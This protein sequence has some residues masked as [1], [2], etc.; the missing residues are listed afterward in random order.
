MSKKAL[1]LP[2]ILVF[3]VIALY[4]CVLVPLLQYVGSDI[5][6]SS[7]LWLDFLDLLSHH[8]EIVGGILV[9]EFLIFVLYRYTL[10][11]AKALLFVIAGAILF[12][13]AAAIIAYSVVFGS[14]DLTGSLSGYAVALAL[15]FLIAALVLLLSVRS[16][17]PAQAQFEA[18]A[19]A[20]ALG[21][22]FEEKDPCY[23][24]ERPLSWKNPVLRTTLLATLAVF[25]AQSAAFV[26][27][28]VTGAPMQGADVPVL[29]VYE[30]LLILL[31]CAYSYFLAVLFFKFCKKQDQKHTVPETK[32]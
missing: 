1:R 2:L 6:L 3:A 17:T 13:Y 16:I 11:R 14:L 8:A 19:A 30:L 22:D 29:L 32:A 9:L 23:P 18:R 5:V 12:K 4:S 27:S 25:V 26:I 21:R 28:F 24:F 7:T 20:K 15:E 31:P 10:T